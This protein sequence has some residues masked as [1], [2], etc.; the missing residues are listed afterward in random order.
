MLPLSTFLA[1]NRNLEPSTLL[2]LQ[3][4]WRPIKLLC[5]PEFHKSREF[6]R[7]LLF[8]SPELYASHSLLPLASYSIRNLLSLLAM[9]DD[10]RLPP[11][12]RSRKASKHRKTAAV[13]CTRSDITEKDWESEMMKWKRARKGCC[14]PQGLSSKSSPLSSPIESPSTGGVSRVY[15]LP[16]L[17]MSD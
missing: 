3:V 8:H 6:Y 16:S 4:Q 5:S 15:T 7:G 2:H 17:D 12:T 14:T 9:S 1:Y 11:L 13:N 10:L